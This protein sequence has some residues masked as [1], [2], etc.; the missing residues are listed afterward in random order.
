MYRV[1][2]KSDTASQLLLSPLFLLF[3]T[4]LTQ[5][6]HNNLQSHQ[7]IL[8]QLRQ[9]ILFSNEVAMLLMQQLLSVLFYQWWNPIVQDW[10]EVL[11]F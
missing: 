3:Q 6:S 10:V 1:L 11:F 4:V 5:H 8:W 2:I 7:P 9:A